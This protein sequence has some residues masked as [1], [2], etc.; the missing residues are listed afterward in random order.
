MSANLRDGTVVDL[1]HE[2]DGEVF[3][4]LRDQEYFACAKLNPE[5]GT[6]EWSNGADFAPEFLY[7]LA[8]KGTPVQNPR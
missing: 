5:T 2:L 1:E 4:A 3:E 7:E 8:T 6:I